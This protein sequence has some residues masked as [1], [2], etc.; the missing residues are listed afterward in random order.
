MLSTLQESL[1]SSPEVKSAK[2][3]LSEFLTSSI[4]SSI[5]GLLSSPVVK[6]TINTVEGVAETATKGLRAPF[7]AAIY[8]TNNKG[9]VWGSVFTVVCGLILGS[10]LM[11]M[12]SQKKK[13]DNKDEETKGED[14]F[15]A[16]W[17]VLIITGIIWVI[18]FLIHLGRMFL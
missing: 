10:T 16:G 13:S 18:L 5:G 15:K 4:K 3:S 8:Y 12:G 1:S 11:I 9:F 2:N 14:M 7:T 17:I 6:N